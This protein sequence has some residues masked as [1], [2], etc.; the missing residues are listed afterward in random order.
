MILNTIVLP[1]QECDGIE[2]LRDAVNHT[3]MELNSGALRSVREVEVS[4]ISNGKV[5]SV[6]TSKCSM[7]ADERYFKGILPVPA[8]LQQVHRHRYLYM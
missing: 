4:L 6:D 1:L 8:S 5:S 7:A 2:A 3:A